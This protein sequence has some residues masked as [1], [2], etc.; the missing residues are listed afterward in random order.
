[1]AVIGGI[2]YLAIFTT[3]VTFFILHGSATVLGPV[4]VMSYT[5]LNPALVMAIGIAMGADGPPLAVIPGLIVIAAATLVLQMGRGGT[6]ER[7]VIGSLARWS[8][9]LRLQQQ[10][11]RQTQR[12]HQITSDGPL[13]W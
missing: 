4:K 7:S 1:M 8:F 12:G 13:V 5:Y 6:T 3:I 2:A 11:I 10:N 9:A